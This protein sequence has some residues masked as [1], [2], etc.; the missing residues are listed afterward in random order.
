MQNSINAKIYLF[1]EN[2]T[3]HAFPVGGI[4][5]ILPIAVG[6]IVGNVALQDPAL[7][8]QLTMPRHYDRTAIQRLFLIIG[9][10]GCIALCA[11]LCL[12]LL[13]LAYMPD[14]LISWSPH[15][16]RDQTSQ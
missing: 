9:W 2:A 8:L 7:E 12:S 14:I 3:I 13:G 5:M 15:A 10:T 16:N 4:E 11:N 6:I 1:H